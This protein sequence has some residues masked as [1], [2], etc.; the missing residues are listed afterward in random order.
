MKD[1]KNFSSFFVLI[2]GTKA[3]IHAFN[4]ICFF[5]MLQKIYISN[6]AIIEEL[7][8]QFPGGLNVITGET[9]AGKSI[10]MG[11]LNLILG[12]RADSTI[13]QNKD[14][15]CI[16]EANF[17]VEKNEGAENF[18]Q[19]NE[20]DAS[21]EILVRREIAVNG[22]SRA[23][24]NDTPV[25][26]TQLKILSSFLLDLHQQFDTLE[27]GTADFQREA[28]DAIAGNQDLLRQMK[29]SFTAYAALNSKLKK[30][31]EQQELAN[32]EMDYH[33]FLFEELDGLHLHENEL[34]RLDE[35]L[36]ILSNA[37]EIKIVLSEVHEQLSGS[38]EPITAKLKSLQQRLHSI[39][40][41]HPGLESLQQR[42]LSSMVEINDI[43]DEL[44]AAD[45][46]VVVDAQRMEIVNDRI[47]EGYKL[48]K[49]H[50][51]RTTADLQLIQEELQQKLSNFTSLGE[52][53]AKL[54]IEVTDA[55]NTCKKIAADLNQARKKAVPSFTKNINAL[56]FR[57]G[58]PSAKIEILISEASLSRLG[59]DEILYLFDANNS[60]RPEPL[61]K[62]ASGGELSRLMLSIKSLVA[63][64]LSLPTLIF[65]EIDTGISGEAARQ[66]GRIMQEM[67]SGHQ[68]I[69]ISHQPQV[70]AQADTHFYV[71]K[72]M[73]ETKLATM[74]KTL[75]SK[76]RINTIAQ[77]IGGE[78]PTAA[79]MENAAELM[80][81]RT[82][83]T[84][85]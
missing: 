53:I 2:G 85:S 9:G 80:E 14:R 55:E 29:F 46:K 33:K 45:S 38:E 83:I 43:A 6:Y 79:A 68:L 12:Q 16:V 72:E 67:S 51:V 18:L 74:V 75:S 48:L 32:R 52:E 36:K 10:L 19:V 57:V 25:N 76:E 1:L 7:T 5:P 44:D 3:Y 22:K 66:V 71:F 77:M 59:S 49:K 31:A 78:K 42:M 23:F 60:G 84:Q 82:K 35:E 17:Y 24:I 54:Q 26:L 39:E 37:E 69:V 70:A 63:K 13:L 27:L 34:E 11:A 21:H 64:K 4:L 40:N 28:L 65:D 20:L 61:H 81:R 8:L 62:V 15:K 58:M 50:N 30:C 73:K 56:L 41:L 47:A